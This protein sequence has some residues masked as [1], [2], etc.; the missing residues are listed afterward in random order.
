M[1]N[2]LITEY[3]VNFEAM[4]NQITRTPFQVENSYITLPTTP[5]LGL[6]LDE[7]ELARHPYRERPL[8]QLRR[9]DNE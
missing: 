8:R 4:G 1:P 9:P 5:G 6:E 3:F 2:F 7:A